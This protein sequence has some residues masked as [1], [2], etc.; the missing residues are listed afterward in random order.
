MTKIRRDTIRIYKERAKRYAEFRE[1]EEIVASFDPMND[2]AMLHALE[3]P[4]LRVLRGDVPR[5]CVDEALRWLGETPDYVVPDS[6]NQSFPLYRSERVAI[7]IQL[8]SHADDEP[9]APA[10]LVGLSEHAMVGCLGLGQLQVGLYRQTDPEPFDVVDPEKALIYCEA[11][12]LRR[13]EHV[14]ARAGYDIIDLLDPVSSPA[15]LTMSLPEVRPFKVIYDRATLRPKCLCGA[16]QV[17]EQLIYV[18]RIAA[19]VGDESSVSLIRSTFKDHHAHHVRWEALQALVRLSPHI[20][21]DCLREAEHDRHPHDVGDEDDR[22]HR[23]DHRHP[24]HWPTRREVDPRGRKGQQR[25]Q[26]AHTGARLGDD[27]RERR[28]LEH[29]TVP[30]DRESGELSEPAGPIRGR[31]LQ[32]EPDGVKESAVRRGSECQERARER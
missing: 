7:S 22:N 18:M 25:Q 12:T 10:D 29:E 3:S 5:L 8:H 2:V 14:V 13:G 4:F 27:E 9:D 32:C 21:V 26:R 28:K 15:Y 20:A 16:N 19:A 24:R 6:T 31:D 1:I 11:R 30:D 23:D 17:D